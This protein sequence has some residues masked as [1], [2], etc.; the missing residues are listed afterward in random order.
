MIVEFIGCTG[1][2]KTTLIR[3]AQSRLAKIT[4]VVIADELVT[5]LI[6]LKH[7][8]NLTVQN[9]IQEFIGFPVFVRSFSRYRPF[10]SFTTKMLSRRAGSSL[11]YFNNLRSLERKIGIYEISQNYKR[12]QIILLDEGFV[13]VAHMFSYDSVPMTEDEIAT[14]I[15]LLP[16]PDLIVYVKASVPIM[17]E[18]TMKRADIPRELKMKDQAQI[19]GTIQ[20]TAQVFDQLVHT[21]AIQ[22]RLLMVE[23][24]KFLEQN[25]SVDC[26][27][28]F[29]LNYRMENS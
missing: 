19:E 13:L 28:K 1:S 15:S 6:G 11:A 12:D 26:I 18:R 23:N 27:V 8:H 20:R 17:V 25:D 2:G 29:I 9:F 5:G 22:S 4:R 16:M 14:F 10:I 21:E 24:S 3:A 7:V